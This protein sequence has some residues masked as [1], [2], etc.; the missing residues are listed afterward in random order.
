MSGAENKKY[1]S[2]TKS[3]VKKIKITFSEVFNNLINS[4]CKKSSNL[5]IIKNCKYLNV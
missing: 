4:N 1:F 3:K 5:L 2:E